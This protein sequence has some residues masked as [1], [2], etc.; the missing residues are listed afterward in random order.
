MKSKKLDRLLEISNGNLGAITVLTEMFNYDCF[1]TM[2][3]KE[4]MERIG[5]TGSKIW[6]G[7]K[8][9]DMNVK[10]FMKRLNRG[11]KTMFEYINVIIEQGGCGNAEPI[12]F[13]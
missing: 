13:F 9:C 5:L 7:Y 11:S 12:K 2:R 8:Y 3:L 6:A 10:K 1:W 4:K